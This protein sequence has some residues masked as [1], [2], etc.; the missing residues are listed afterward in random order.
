MKGGGQ[1]P[2]P[3][4]IPVPVFVPQKYAGGIPNNYDPAHE[5]TWQGINKPMP[6][7]AYVNKQQER[8]ATKYFYRCK[9]CGKE[10]SSPIL[11]PTT[12]VTEDAEC[13]EKD[14]DFQPDV[15]LG[16]AYQSYVRC[17]KCGVQRIK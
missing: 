15:S 12:T 1:L 4:M 10:Q 3:P 17:T 6:A 7:I 5:H 2:P 13:Q 14:H 16:P 9:I 11:L 8:L